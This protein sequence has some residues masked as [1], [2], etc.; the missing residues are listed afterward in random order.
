MQCVRPVNVELPDGR[1]VPRYA[2]DGRFMYWSH[3][4]QVPCG[5]CIACRLNK[6]KQW[7]TRLL[8]E[9]CM[10]SDA[11]FLTLT[12][13]DANIPDDFGLHKS[14]LQNFFKR[15]R[16]DIEKEGRNIKYFATGE[17]GDKFGRPHYHAIVFGL[18]P[19][20]DRFYFDRCWQLGNLHTGTVRPA[21]INY[22]SKYLIKKIDGVLE[23]VKYGDRLPP[24]QVQSTMLGLSFIKKYYLDLA[25]VGYFKFN[26]K[27]YPFDRYV[28]DKILETI[29]LNHGDKSPEYQSYMR[30][31]MDAFR[32]MATTQVSDRD[33]YENSIFSRINR[34]LPPSDRIYKTSYYYSLEDFEKKEKV[35]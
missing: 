27:S 35:I 1:F 16:Y 3:Y 7:A 21:S 29:I 17:Y 20:D 22:V 8:M 32:F 12:Y 5:H 28:K 9:S 15:L 26:D 25:D 34:Y 11:T 13:S 31:R 10:W 24:F 19:W 18:S 4:A 6:K 33:F 2:P 14:H 23:K 30:N